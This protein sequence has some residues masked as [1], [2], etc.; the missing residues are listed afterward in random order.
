MF[1]LLM[2]TIS[3]KKCIICTVWYI[4]V[5]AIFFNQEARIFPSLGKNV[6]KYDESFRIR[7]NYFYQAWKDQ[8]S[9]MAKRSNDLQPFQVLTEYITKH[10]NDQLEQ[11]WLDCVGQSGPR[12]ENIT[13]D[14]IIFKESES[15]NSIKQRKFIV[16]V[17][18]CPQ[19]AGN[20]LHRFMNALLWSILT[21]RTLLYRYHTYDSCVEYDE[22][23][24]PCMAC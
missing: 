13:T 6:L 12:R 19:E 20:R 15:C 8:G 9:A 10:S 23:Q 18:S 7:F 4:F 17:Y 24:G 2:P 16:G 22:G 3:Q 11:E 1:T 14:F 5:T 21:N